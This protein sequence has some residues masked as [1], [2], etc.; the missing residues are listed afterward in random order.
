MCGSGPGRTRPHNRRCLRHRS[1]EQPRLGRTA[2]VESNSR[3]HFKRLLYSCLKQGSSQQ[4]QG[5]V[6]AALSR[7]L[8]LRV[9][10]TASA[11]R[12][13][14]EA[15]SSVLSTSSESWI[16]RVGR[17]NSSTRHEGCGRSV[18]T[19]NTGRVHALSV[20]ARMQIAMF[21]DAC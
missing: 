7:Q 17:A 3:V 19:K 20:S 2:A 6:V 8:E 10:C 15:A 21:L 18:K 14:T 13:S 12:S 9:R 5:V 11:S 16:A 4:T 1:K